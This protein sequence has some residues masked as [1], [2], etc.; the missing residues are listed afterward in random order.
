MLIRQREWCIGKNGDMCYERSFV[1]PNRLRVSPTVV[2]RSIQSLSY[3]YL[4][5]NLILSKRGCKIVIFRE[6]RRPRHLVE[7]RV[8]SIVMPLIKEKKFRL[9]CFVCFEKNIETNCT[10]KK[11]QDIEKLNPTSF[12]RDKLNCFKS[13]VWFNF[14][15]INE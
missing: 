15:F 3:G 6:G 8:S 10:G 13:D 12:E 11:L 4:L 14:Y 1:F 7:A 9:V 5:L 2:L